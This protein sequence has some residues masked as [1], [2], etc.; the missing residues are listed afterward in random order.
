VGSDS[1]TAVIA[2]I[3]ANVAITITKF[4][5]AML[6]GSAAMFAEAI[7]SL[8]N[9]FDGTLLLL[10]AWRA[11]RPPDELHPFGHGRELY[12]WNLIVAI[13]FFALGSGFTIYEGIRR[14][15][16][17]E[18]LGDPKWSYVVLAVSALFDGTS[19]VIGF[20]RF[21]R[22]TRGRTYWATIRQSK[23]PALF[24]VVLEDTAD[25]AG[26][27]LAAI[28]VYLSHALGQPRI[29]GVASIAIGLVL[30]AMA[31]VLLIETHGLLI[32]EAATPELTQSVRAIASSDGAVA[33]VEQMLTVQLG[34][35]DVVVAIRV[36]LRADLEPAEITAATSRVEDRIKRHHGEV[37]RVFVELAASAAADAQS[38]RV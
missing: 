34:P 28:G 31:T 21:R 37:K 2:S 10:G 33:S 27:S 38:R 35:S 26:L 13:I 3:A 23:D 19:F 11:K 6:S 30:G 32:G 36:A 14:V 22:V 4:L 16:A 18:T 24:S 12:F 8:V 9:C 5:V 7:H 1:R 25:L 29:D 20:R 15:L 17:P